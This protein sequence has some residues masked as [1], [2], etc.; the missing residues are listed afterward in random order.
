MEM[1]HTKQVNEILTRYGCG[2]SF[3]EVDSVRDDKTTVKVRFC[4][5]ESIEE[6]DLNNDHPN[7]RRLVARIDRFLGDKDFSGLLHASACIFET[8]PESRVSR[9]SCFCSTECQR[10]DKMERRRTKAQKCC[11]LCG[12]ASRKPQTDQ[13]AIQPSQAF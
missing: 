3:E 4:R 13:T 11:R 1:M 6:V 10:I 9:G 5:S 7:V 12:R 2:F 8:I